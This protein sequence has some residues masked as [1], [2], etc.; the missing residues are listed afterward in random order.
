MKKLIQSTIKNHKNGYMP[1]PM[2]TGSGKSYNAVEILYEALLNQDDKRKYIFITP[3]LKNKVFDD[4]KKKCEKENKMEPFE[5]FAIDLKSNQDMLLEN[6]R[7]VNKGE[8]KKIKELKTPYEDLE[9]AIKREEILNKN[10]QGDKEAINNADYTFRKILHKELKEKVGSKGKV[11]EAI[12]TQGSEW[13]WI[14]KMYPGYAIKDKKIICMSVAK[15][16]FQ[17]D[18]IIESPFLFYKDKEFDG[19]VIL[20]D[21]CDSGKVAMLNSLINGDDNYNKIKL[22]ELFKNIHRAVNRNIDSFHKYLFAPSLKQKEN[23]KYGEDSLKQLVV[24]LKNRANEIYEQFNLHYDLKTDDSMTREESIIFHDPVNSFTFGNNDEKPKIVGNNDLQINQITYNENDNQL[25]L[26]HLMSSIEHYIVR[27][28]RS[29]LT[30]SINYQEC[31]KD[32][33]INSYELIDAVN[34]VLTIFQIDG[35]YANYLRKEIIYG[36]IGSAKKISS[37]IGEGFYFEGFSLHTIEDENA[38]DLNSIIYKEQHNDTPEKILLE[39]SQKSLVIGLSATADIPSCIRNFDLNFLKRELKDDYLELDKCELFRLTENYDNL[40]VGYNNV[41]IKTHFS[42]VYEEESEDECWIYL[43]GDGGNDEFAHEVIDIIKTRLSNFSDRQHLFNLTYAFDKF[44][45]N[46]EICSFLCV[47][48]TFFKEHLEDDVKSIFNLLVQK[49]KEIDE[50]DISMIDIKNQL[51]VLDSDNYKTTKKEILQ[52]LSNG[53]RLFVISTYPTIATGQNLQYPAPECLFSDRRLVWVN[54]RDNKNKE[55]DFDAIYLER[56]TNIITNING[57]LSNYDK[58][59]ALYECEFLKESG[60]ISNYVMKTRMDNIMTGKRNSNGMNL[61]DK[62]SVKNGAMIQIIQ[63]IGRIG[64]T[65]IKNHNIYIFADGSIPKKCITSDMVNSNRLYSPEV[66]KFIED[67]IFRADI[68]EDVAEQEYINRAVNRSEL[69]YKNLNDFLKKG[70]TSEDDVEFWENTRDSLLKDPQGLR[71][72]N[73]RLFIELPEKAKCYYYRQKS[74]YKNVE[75]SFRNPFEDGNS[76]SSK[77][78]RLDD[79]MK[80]N[81]IKEFMISEGYATTFVPSKKM[82]APVI[83]NNIYKG[84]LGEVIGKYLVEKYTSIKLRNIRNLN[85][86]EKFDYES[87]NHVYF[88]FKN[89]SENTRFDQKDY[90]DKIVGKA[91]ECEARLIVIPNLM[92]EENY[93]PNEEDIDGIHILEIP[94]LVKVTDRGIDIDYSMLDLIEKV[95][96]RYSNELSN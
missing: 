50:E 34:T 94:Q 72:N 92:A 46:P 4:L 57:K 58:V 49:H 33:N 35:E 31:K 85:L 71:S 51:V 9:K 81:E 80:N 13:E 40:N 59:L 8:V 28:M 19:S 10:G 21:E 18:S 22:I 23:K 73:S 32:Q 54:K 75:I 45:N 47:M 1:L 74:D 41:E 88:D 48:N 7:K 17:Y 14:G 64:R 84:A 86:Y 52:R 42:K 25:Y 37:N 44:I 91:K 67:A 53:E 5:K 65:N 66:K 26:T 93:K 89:W 82:M 12:E 96:R 36:N 6:F 83:A 62:R 16:I 27:F 61:Y 70:Y 24:E 3:S 69:L 39:M 55:K 78:T 56:P 15:Y 2:P 68:K 11:K 30:L 60:E 77:T 29:C 20:F 63:A 76:V 90:L 38:H 87:D 43:F 79:L 95:Y